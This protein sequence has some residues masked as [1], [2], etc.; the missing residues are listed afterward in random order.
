[1][2]TE[3]SYS[4]SVYPSGDGISVYWLDV[5]ERRRAEEALKNARDE[6]EKR[7]Q[8]RTADLDEA[9]K[10]LQAEIIQRKRMEDTLRESEK[11]VRL[12]ASQ[13]L[14]AQE[15]E[16]RRIAA[17]L[18]DS[19]ASSLAGVKFRIEKIAQDM[20]QDLGRVEPL[21]DLSLDVAQSLGEVRRIMADLR[22]SI[23][24]DLG[25]I[26]AL[27]WFC[28][29]YQKT[30]P[31]ISVEK[32]VEIT[33]EEVPD[34][35]KTVIFRISQEA[36]S[37]IARHS[38]ASL[39]NLYLQK[40]GERL[41]LSVQDNGQGFDPEKVNKGMGLSNIRERAELSGGAFDLETAVGKGTIIRASWP[42]A[43]LQ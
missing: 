31:Q 40:E 20:K 36:M 38:K 16:R 2:L 15:T 19:I 14:T 25:I 21:Q 22:P 9:V 33:E 8:E 32:Q 17:E 42:L 3:R 24:D 41:L 27:S 12:F 18:H 39:V 37:N 35:L 26:P 43:S 4:I 1:V 13:C 10:R 11:Q 5:T 29:E 34:A 23:L 6:L 30:Y 7:V 28:R